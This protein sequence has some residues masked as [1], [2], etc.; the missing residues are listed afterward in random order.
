MNTK[1]VSWSYYT[2]SWLSDFIVQYIAKNPNISTK[3]SLLEPSCWDGSFLVSISKNKGILKLIDKITICEN[4]VQELEKASKIIDSISIQ[5]DFLINEITGKF[6]LVIGNPPYIHKKRIPIE[7][8]NEYQKWYMYAGLGKTK[9]QNIWPAFIYKSESL[10]K[11]NGMM[12]FVIPEELLR[13]N[14]WNDVLSFLKEKFERIEIYSIDKIIFWDAG[15][16][17][18]T[19][20]AYKKHLQKWLYQWEIILQW[21]KDDFSIKTVHLLDENLF[22]SS[23]KDFWTALKDDDLKFIEKIYKK[24][25]TVSQLA[26]SKTGIVTWANKFFILKDSDVKKYWLKKFCIPIMQKSSSIKHSMVFSEEEFNKLKY[27]N[28]PCYFLRVQ[29]EAQDKNVQNYLKIGEQTELNKRFKL[30]S[31][32]PNWYNIPNVVHS[33]LVFFKRSHLYPKLILNTYGSQVTDSG[34]KIHLKTKWK[35]KQFQYSF[36]NSFTLLMSEILGRY[37]GGWVLELTPNEFKKLPIPFVEDI[38]NDKLKKFYRKDFSRID[39]ILIDNDEYVLK[40]S[41]GLSSKD[42]QRIR[43][44]RTKLTK[45]RLKGR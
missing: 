36:Y 26:D 37:Y 43:D 24:L 14:Y 25:P 40:Q 30:S 34:Y 28:K 39:E 38:P 23:Q 3:F 9:I 4:S 8:R 11:E 12:A 29:W 35:E 32:W 20:F 7:R 18:I 6:D 22:H 13:V 31:Y 33:E 17:T 16:N 5:W 44:I 21:K 19:L 15:Q 2:P 1:K 42:I 41:Y 27:Q 45:R 10:L